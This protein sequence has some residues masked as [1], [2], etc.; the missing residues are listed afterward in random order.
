MKH[1]PNIL[2]SFRFVLTVGFIFC[3]MQSGVA[4]IAAATVFFLMA[5]ISDFYDGYFAKKF[6]L[7]SNFG[8]IMDPIADKFLILSAFF[9][10]LVKGLV[11][12]WMFYVIFIRELLVTGTRLAAIRKGAFIAAEQAGKLKTALQMT[13]VIFLLAFLMVQE[14]G[15][16]LSWQARMEGLLGR[17][18]AVLLFFAVGLTLFSGLTYLWNNRNILL[19]DFRKVKCP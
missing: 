1:L 17:V 13:V 18:N 8:K 15:I 5:V 10:L 2:T 7:T 4:P 9:M 16:T 11:P 6:H 12:L 14:K 3:L 19:A